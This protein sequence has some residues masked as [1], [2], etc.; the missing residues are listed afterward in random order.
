MSPILNLSIP[1]TT[2]LQALPDAHNPVEHY[3]DAHFAL[4][5][6]RAEF[7][8]D[9]LSIIELAK[10]ENDYALICQQ[11]KSQLNPNT[12]KRSHYPAGIEREACRQGLLQFL[13]VPI[14]ARHLGY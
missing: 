13:A 10:A 6:A 14:H 7:T 8:Q 5:E 9:K 1:I 12:S 4:S 11:I 3:H 2:E